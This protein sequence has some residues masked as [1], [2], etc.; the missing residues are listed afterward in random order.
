[1]RTLKAPASVEQ[2]IADALA[3]MGQLRFAKRSVV[4]REFP[5][6]E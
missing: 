5:A 1:V 2:R 3:L 6:L 4:G